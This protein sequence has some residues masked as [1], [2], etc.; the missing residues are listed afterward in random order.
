VRQFLERLAESFW[1]DLVLC[2]FFMFYGFVCLLMG[3][4]MYAAFLI[5][6]G[7]PFFI[8]FWQICFAKQ[9]G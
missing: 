7:V 8:L 1:I 3:K 6:V 4:W 5:G 2:W 9:S